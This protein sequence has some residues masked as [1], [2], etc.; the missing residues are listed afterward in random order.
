MGVSR[1]IKERNPNVQ[2]IGCQPTAGSKIPGIR[3]WPKEYLPKFFEPER[4]DRT[5][6]ISQSDAEKQA[7]WLASKVGLFCGISAAGATLV[8]QQVCLEL[9]EGIVVTVICDRGDRYLSAPVFEQ[10]GNQVVVSS[11]EMER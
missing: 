4:V 6:D 8:A 10:S 3:R 5:I 9:S 1:F 2:I 7:R 11:L